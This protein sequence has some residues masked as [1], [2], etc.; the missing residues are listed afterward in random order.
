MRKY[1][2]DP[3]GRLRLLYGVR[4]HGALR[5]RTLRGAV[6]LGSALL[7]ASCGWLIRSEGERSATLRGHDPVGYFTV[8]MPMPGRPE[9]KAEHEGAFYSFA[10]ETNRRLFITSPDRYVPQFGGLCAQSMGYAIPAEGDAGAFKIIDGRLY[11][12]SSRRARQYFE[13]DQ[14]R[15]LRLAWHYWDAEVRDSTH[16]LQSLR[17]QVFRVP[18]YKSTAELDA[19]YERRVAAQ[20]N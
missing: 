3:Q 17:R 2:L 13:M 4:L 14:E 10:N 11:L 7:L 19:E 9:L 15:N 5:L 8:G 16:W 6:V 18:H 20:K 1:D 12:F